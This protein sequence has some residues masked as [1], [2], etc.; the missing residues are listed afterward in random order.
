MLMLS[1]YAQPGVHTVLLHLIV[2]TGAVISLHCPV[3]LHVYPLEHEPQLR[4]PPQPSLGEPHWVNPSWAQVF[5]MH[6]NLNDP[7]TLEVLFIH[8][9]G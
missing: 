7:K 4:V 2:V 8:I 3:A 5:G 9:P 1:S 6:A